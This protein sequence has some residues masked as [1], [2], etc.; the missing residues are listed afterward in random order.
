MS[1]NNNEI[2]TFEE[3]KPNTKNKS[4]K[5]EKDIDKVLKKEDELLKFNKK[6]KLDIRKINKNNES[7]IEGISLREENEE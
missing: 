3:E 4:T 7:K 1:N 5:D 6:K 2:I